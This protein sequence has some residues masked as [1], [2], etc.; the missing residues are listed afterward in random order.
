MSTVSELSALG[1][2]RMRLPRWNKHAY[3][4]VPAIGRWA[5]L[6]DVNAGLVSGLPM[7][8][9]IADCDRHDNWVPVGHEPTT[10]E[11]AQQ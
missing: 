5:E 4:E 6:F 3:L 2:R 10:T 8:M 9:L 11:G 7:P 1:H